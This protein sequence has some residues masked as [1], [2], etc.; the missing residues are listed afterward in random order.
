MTSFPPKRWDVRFTKDID[1]LTCSS[2]SAFGSRG[3]GISMEAFLVVKPAAGEE[4]SFR[5]VLDGPEK[6]NLK[7]NVQSV[8]PNANGIFSDMVTEAE[9]HVGQHIKMQKNSCCSEWMDVA[10]L[11]R[12]QDIRISNRLG[13]DTGEE[14]LHGMESYKKDLT[15]ETGKADRAGIRF[16][17]ILGTLGGDKRVKLIAHV[18]F[19]SEFRNFSNS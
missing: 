2:A 13:K 19:I 11:V 8:L 1:T 12:S 17:W 7:F 5:F 4:G 18:I 10:E 15:Q 16:R 6:L 3:L 9:L 14:F